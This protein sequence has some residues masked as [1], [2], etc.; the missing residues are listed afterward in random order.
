MAEFSPFTYYPLMFLILFVTQYELFQGCEQH[1]Y[2]AKRLLEYGNTSKV[3]VMDT[4]TTKY[5]L[6]K[7]ENNTKIHSKTIQQTIQIQNEYE[8]KYALYT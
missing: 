8:Y 2:L 3:H 5:I 6:K 4:K 1:K 7:Y